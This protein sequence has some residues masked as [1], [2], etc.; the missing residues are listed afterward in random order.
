VD[1]VLVFSGSLLHVI[2]D[3]DDAGIFA[4]RTRAFL[5]FGALGGVG[6]GLKFGVGRYQSIS[7]DRAVLAAASMNGLAAKRVI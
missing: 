5:A 2:D 7:G 1:K 4:V 3:E 6:G